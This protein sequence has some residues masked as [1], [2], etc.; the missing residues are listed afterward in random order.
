[1]LLVVD[2]NPEKASTVAEMLY[3]MGYL[4]SA[5]E[6]EE[7][8]G[9]CEEGFSAILF[10][11]P[12]GSPDEAELV[13]LVRL[14]YDAPI[15]AMTPRR[16][17][18][19][20]GKSDAIL[21][22]NEKRHNTTT[23]LS[24][25]EHL[26]LSDTKFSAC[27]GGIDEMKLCTL[28]APEHHRNTRVGAPPSGS[29]LG[30]EGY[31]Y[32]LPSPGDRAPGCGS[33][34]D[35]IIDGEIFSPRSV[36]RICLSLALY[37]KEPLGSYTG[38]GIDASVDAA[39]VFCSGERIPLTRTET[40]IVRY[41]IHRSPRSATAEEILA[42]AFRQT[43]APEPTSVRTHISIINKKFRETVGRPLTLPSDDGTYSLCQH[44]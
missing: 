8:P 23:I 37:G 39:G 38:G 15:F 7:A 16:A 3:Y 29:D 30:A 1:M 13:E 10:T 32:S 2:K 34:F 43:R 6:P 4:A 35:G 12:D 20:G 42:H 33:L 11:S 21:Y 25:F 18:S 24:I 44:S 14:L 26:R 17:R 22:G 9:A 5:I 31:D 40:M 41:L 36:E 28:G 19:A 27:H